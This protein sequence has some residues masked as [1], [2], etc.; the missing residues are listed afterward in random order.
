M[1]L[2]TLAVE[3]ICAEVYRLRIFWK[4]LLEWEDCR[5]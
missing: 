4:E 5:A 1:F 2:Y 3:N